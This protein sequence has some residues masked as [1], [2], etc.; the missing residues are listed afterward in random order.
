[1][2]KILSEQLIFEAFEVKYFE[3]CLTIFLRL[4]RTTMAM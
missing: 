2:L 4:V 1:M 3:Y